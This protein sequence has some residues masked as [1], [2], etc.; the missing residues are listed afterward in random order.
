MEE[1]MNEINEIIDDINDQMYIQE[2]RKMLIYTCVYGEAKRRIK[3]K[4]AIALMLLFKAKHSQVNSSTN[5]T[6]KYERSKKYL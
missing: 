4:Y 6:T 1:I 3:I 5:V 2:G